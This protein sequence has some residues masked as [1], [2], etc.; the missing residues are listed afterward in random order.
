M[1]LI[2]TSVMDLALA[3]VKHK[4]NCALECGQG[5]MSFAGRVTGNSLSKTQNP[6]HERKIAENSHF[7]YTSFCTL[8]YNSTQIS[9][10]YLKQLQQ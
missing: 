1:K 4:E 9:D 10:T 5:I 2:V 3:F 8:Q 6:T 7:E